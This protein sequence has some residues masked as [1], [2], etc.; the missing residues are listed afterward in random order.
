MI[1]SFLSALLFLLYGSLSFA[2]RFE[3]DPDQEAYTGHKSSFLEF[4]DSLVGLIVLVALILLIVRHLQKNKGGAKSPEEEL[5]ERI[6]KIVEKEFKGASVDVSTPI[7]SNEH[8]SD[9]QNKVDLPRLNSEEKVL[10]QKQF[11]G[12]YARCPK[13]KTESLRENLS[14][15]GLAGACQWCTFQFTLPVASE[16]DLVY[17][18]YDSCP[19]CRLFKKKEAWPKEGLNQANQCPRCSHEFRRGS[20]R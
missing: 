14:K 4:Y 5:K 12:G 19:K 16:E 3:A 9:S 8:I 13:C 20:S 18:I 1:K 17:E 11:H 7:R 15:D 2:R 6:S 10:A